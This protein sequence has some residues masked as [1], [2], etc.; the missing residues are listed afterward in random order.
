M[1]AMLVRIGGMNPFSSAH[2]VRNFETPYPQ[3]FLFLLDGQ[4]LSNWS[5]EVVLTS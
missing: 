4:L 5:E 3:R 2:G 1:R